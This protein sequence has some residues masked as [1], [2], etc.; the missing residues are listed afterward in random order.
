MSSLALIRDL[1]SSSFADW[2]R[3]AYCWL[4]SNTSASKLRA[5]S[6]CCLVN[7]SMVVLQL[8]KGL[9]PSDKTIDCPNT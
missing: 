8:I 2:L 9:F 4:S 7:V 3:S 6:S 5:V 1:A